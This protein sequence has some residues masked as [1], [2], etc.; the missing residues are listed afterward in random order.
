M[1]KKK[2]RERDRSL[3]SPFKGRA[4]KREKGGKQNGQGE[5]SDGNKGSGGFGKRGKRTSRA[6]KKLGCQG[7]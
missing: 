4:K 2:N 7:K 6:G 5:A 1:K 3:A